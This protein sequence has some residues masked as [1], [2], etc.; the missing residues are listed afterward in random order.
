MLRAWTLGSDVVK[1]FPSTV[2]GPGYFKD[3]LEKVYLNEFKT[4]FAWTRELTERF[5]GRVRVP[6][7]RPIR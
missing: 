5:Q 1:V 6:C 7:V 3:I 2:L 4:A